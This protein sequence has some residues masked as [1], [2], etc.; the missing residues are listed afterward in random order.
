[1]RVLHRQV[2]R[3]LNFKYGTE[4]YIQYQM[5]ESCPTIISGR[6]IETS[7]IATKISYKNQIINIC[8]Y[9]GIGI[10]GELKILWHKSLGFESLQLHHNIINDDSERR[11]FNIYKVRLYLVN[12]NNQVLLYYFFKDTYSNFF[13]KHIIQMI[14]KSKRLCLEQLHRVFL[15]VYVSHWPSW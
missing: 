13:L 4:G 15:G 8:S 9:D 5:Q 3:P 1:M 12:V 10:H 11:D 14:Y 2:R 7:R 6:C